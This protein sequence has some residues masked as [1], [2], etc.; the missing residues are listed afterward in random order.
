[1][2]SEGARAELVSASR[3]LF[4]RFRLRDYA[5][6]DFRLDESGAP[7]FLE[8]NA[9]CGWCWDGHLAKAASFAEMS[10]A[11]LLR[12]IVAAAARRLALGQDK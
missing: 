7:V 6:F 11:E 9:N 4:T 12:A 8:A 1:M 10:Y 2:L 5:R 3:Q